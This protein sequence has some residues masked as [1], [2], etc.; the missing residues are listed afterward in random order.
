MGLKCEKDGI[1]RN[2]LNALFLKVKLRIFRKREP[3]CLINEGLI[4]TISVIKFMSMLPT[5][6]LDPTSNATLLTFAM[7]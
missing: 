2:P 1:D 3:L 6:I 4:S 5:L 7:F